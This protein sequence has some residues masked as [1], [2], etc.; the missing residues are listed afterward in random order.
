MTTYSQTNPFSVTAPVTDT[1]THFIRR[2]VMRAITVKKTV[3]GGAANGT[4][5]IRVNCGTGYDET[6][7][8]AHNGSEILWVPLDRSCEITET[9]PGAGVIG[10]GN[11]NTAVIN[12]SH[13]KVEDDQEVLVTNRI[14][15]GTI[16]KAWVKVTKNISGD[17]A[18]I[19]A[20]HDPDSLFDIIVTCGTSPQ[21]DLKLKAGQSATVEGEVGE[22]C[23]IDEPGFPPMADPGY[24]YVL[25][26][27]PILT[28]LQ[29]AGE[30]V[31]VSVDNKVMPSGIT[32]HEIALTNMVGAPYPNAYNQNGRFVLTLNCGSI[33]WT[34]NPL[35]AG[36]K[37]SVS[38]PAGSNCET[39]VDQRP[40][41]SPGYVWRDGNG[42]HPDDT[43]YSLGRT[44]TTGNVDLDGTVTHFLKGENEE[45]ITIVKTL[46]GAT[47]LFV[48]GYYEV[49]L[50]CNNGFGS[51]VFRFDHPAPWVEEKVLVPRG[52]LCTVS[53]DTSNASVGTGTSQETI[54]PYQFTVIEG[55]QTV[56]IKTELLGSP[57]NMTKLYVKKE[58]RMGVPLP[59]GNGHD[60]STEFVIE[61]QCPGTFPGVTTL[62]L[63]GDNIGSVD[64]AIGDTCTI[65][66][67]VIPSARP[68]FIYWASVIPSSLSVPAGGRSATVIN[69]VRMGNPS[70]AQIIFTQATV[71]GSVVESGYVP[72]I[73]NTTINCG[74]GGVFNLPLM[75]GEEAT[76]TVPTGTVCSATRGV[77]PSLANNLD[78]RYDGPTT[79]PAMPFTVN[80]NGTVIIHY[81]IVPVIRNLPTPIP[82]L[83]PKA[84][85]LLIGLLSGLVFWRQSRQPRRQR[86]DQ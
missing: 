79:T 52:S 53:E 15:H 57:I 29:V 70:Q 43:D 34:T 58:V 82:T 44:F 31:N 62:P 71:T 46:T 78:F 19:A 85:L 74:T 86:V 1:V 49:T 54:A 12:P 2:D 48:G 45:E 25:A 11:S 69:E 23:V 68:G 59:I 65:A 5:A 26:I 67:P 16:T 56:Y 32:V 14:E 7:N 76:V 51:Q 36:D 4:F 47:A 55:G 22:E 27:S 66:E 28:E 8:L 24:Q 61:V 10:G 13:F 83:D 75:E 38:V 33:I 63:L 21:A 35:R 17:P 81:G 39:I 60:P 84:L 73:L 72:G 64:V 77:L 9:N 40:T 42:G 3:T 41:P 18:H 80:A 6:V 37:S 50:A 30:T 20:G